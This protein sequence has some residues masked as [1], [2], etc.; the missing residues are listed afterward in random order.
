MNKEQLWLVINKLSELSGDISPVGETNED[1]KRH[2]NLLSQG[3]FLIRM[4]KE[5]K[6]VSNE[7]THNRFSVI[8]AVK[9]S[10]K[11]IN[12]IKELIND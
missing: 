3:E 11:I 9:S 2:N 6:E 12:D 4:I 10:E 5:I 7:E 8:R 1:E